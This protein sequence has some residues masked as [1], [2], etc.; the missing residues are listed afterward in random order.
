MPKHVMLMT[1]CLCLSVSAIAGDRLLRRAAPSPAGLQPAAASLSLSLLGAAV[2]G[3]AA[4]RLDRGEPPSALSEQRT[5]LG[6]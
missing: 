1:A 4:H 6:K 2:A 3:G 5:A